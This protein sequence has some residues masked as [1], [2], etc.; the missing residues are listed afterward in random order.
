MITI[1]EAHKEVPKTP[2]CMTQ[3]QLNPAELIIVVTKDEI[4]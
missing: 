3:S 4:V 1:R 2:V